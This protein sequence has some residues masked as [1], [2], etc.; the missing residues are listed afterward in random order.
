VA[1]LMDRDI[2]PDHIRGLSNRRLVKMRR[3]VHK[4]L[5]KKRS[6]IMK[7]GAETFVMYGPEYTSS[8]SRALKVADDEIEKRKLYHPAQPRVKDSAAM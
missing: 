2:D 3:S 5:E 7:N 1:S 6:E 4:N 8:M